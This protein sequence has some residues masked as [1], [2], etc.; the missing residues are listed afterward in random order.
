MIYKTAWEYWE[1]CAISTYRWKLFRQTLKDVI[2]DRLGRE[3]H[4]YS[5]LF[6]EVTPDDVIAVAD[7]IHDKIDKEKLTEFSEKAQS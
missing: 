2:S 7:I 5:L 4:G 6:R 1:Y 3:F